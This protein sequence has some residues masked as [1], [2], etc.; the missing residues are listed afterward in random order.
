GG[1]T[2]YELAPKSYARSMSRDSSDELS[3]TTGNRFSPASERIHE[4][5]PKPSSSGI[6]KS[7]NSRVGNGHSLRSEN[8]PSPLRYL[9]ASAPSPTLCKGFLRPPLSNASRINVTKL[10]SS[11]AI[12]TAFEIIAQHTG[13]CGT[14]QSQTSS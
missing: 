7:S 10:S 3:I 2:A 4:S 5:T 14:P 9:I 12:K 11:S 6:F 13:R 1:F 8:F